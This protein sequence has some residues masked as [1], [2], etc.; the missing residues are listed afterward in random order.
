MW[1][2]LGTSAVSAASLTLT[3]QTN[4]VYC[5]IEPQ[6]PVCQLLEE[7]RPNDLPVRSVAVL[8]HAPVGHI[9]F[10]WREPPGVVR[11]VRQ[12]PYTEYTEAVE[13]QTV[14]VI[15]LFLYSNVHNSEQAFNDE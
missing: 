7:H 15:E 1:T 4:H 6:L 12:D 5:D 3:A 2:A 9:S 14:S 8:H 13:G 10:T 11:T